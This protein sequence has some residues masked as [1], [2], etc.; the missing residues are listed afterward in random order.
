MRQVAEARS[1]AAQD[2]LQSMMGASGLEPW[3]A[4]KGPY[5]NPLPRDGWHISKSHC[6]DRVAAALARAPVGV[7]VE[8]IRLSKLSQW[9]RVVDDAEREILGEVDALA[10][11]RLWTAKE[12]ILKADGIG[13]G[14]LS[15]C[16]LIGVPGPNRLTFRH[17][18]QE[19]IVQQRV[20]GGPA[21]GHVLSVYVDGDQAVSWEP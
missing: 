9:K 15:K 11:T 17:R 13:I 1:L 18:G 20:L 3:I 4:D 2:L 12:A 19:K 8:S 10:F 5:G 6:Q 7:D 21:Q 14:G 16:R